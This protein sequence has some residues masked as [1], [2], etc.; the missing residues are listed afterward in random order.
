MK[1]K[2]KS[3]RRHRRIWVL[4]LHI[5]I[6]VIGSAFFVATRKDMSEAEEHLSSTVNYV[7]EQCNRYTCIDLA[8]ETK[9]LMRIIQSVQQIQ[10]KIYY[11]A[12]L[13]PTFEVNEEFLEKCSRDSYVTGIVLLNEKGVIQKQYQAD[14][15]AADEVEGYL[16]T[17]VL[18]STAYFPEKTYSARVSCRDGSYI[19]LAA[20]GM[21]AASGIIVTYYHTSRKYMDAFSLSYS[22]M[23]S[24]YNL[25]H[26]GTIVV[27]EGNNIIASNDG[28][29]IGKSTD[30]IAVLRRIKEKANSDKLTHA[31]NEE[32]SFLRQFGLME[33]GRDYYVY[34]YMPE[35]EVFNSTLQNV[36]Y[37]LI[38]YLII[39]AVINMVRW[40]TAQGYREDQL[41]IQQ[42]YANNLQEKNEL[43][44]QAVDQADRANAAKTSFLS[45]MSHDIRTPLNGIIGLLEIDQAH[46]DNLESHCTNQKKMLVSAN[47]LLSL[48]NDV[49]QMSKLESG[50][51]ILSHEPMDL[52]QLSK[53]VLMIVEQR[54]AE[55]GITLEYDKDSDR[56]EHNIV[57]GSPLHIR[58]IFLNIYSNC[59]KYNKVGGMVETSC[60]CLG[61]ENG[62]VTYRWTIRDTGIGMNEEFL[63]HIF[64][65]FAQERSDAR[66]VY[67]GTGLGMSIVKSLID[68][69]NGTIKITSKEGVGSVFVLTIPF[70]IADRIPKI[71]PEKQK[72]EVGDIQGYHLLIAED[73]ELNAE[74]AKT[75]L[76]DEGAII[77]LVHNGQQAIDMFKEKPQGTFDAILMDVMMPVVDGLS[78][79]RSIRAL[80]REDA[81]KIPIIA[82]TANAF[83]EDVKRCIEAGMNAHLPKPLEMNKVVETIAKYCR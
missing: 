13:S 66:S 68:L 17:E 35:N 67:N 32:D 60:C 27:S 71:Q 78:A 76:E 51:V 30:D 2:R 70:E 20:A 46:P 79:T 23:L 28:K 41:R 24:G 38:V 48:I 44:R 72:D 4:E 56:V 69:M 82:V 18:L 8:S 52:R 58:Q 25:Q 53:E 49:L 21:R 75:L 81:K 59:I 47:Y 54:A 43:L 6:L 31:K 77:T 3:A 34:A 61:I 45:R 37:S 63:K 14:E 80:G 7:K 36:F 12:E 33:H 29:L 65:P 39:L 55:A 9:S 64:D 73:N 40:K 57:Y 50:K 42:E 83:D 5:G 19:D 62:I 22:S 26:D 15:L 74:I 11:E 10:N 1:S 16:D